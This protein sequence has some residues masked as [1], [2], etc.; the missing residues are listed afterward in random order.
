MYEVGLPCY[1]LARTKEQEI[2]IFIDWHS[3]SQLWLAP[4]SYDDAVE[5]PAESEDQVIFRS[6]VEVEQAWSRGQTPIHGVGICAV[7]NLSKFRLTAIVYN[8]C[9]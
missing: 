9:S 1:A 4:W 5:L 8:S 6:K 7:R 2:K 3:Y